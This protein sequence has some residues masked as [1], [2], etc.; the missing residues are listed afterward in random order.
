MNC[1][2]ERTETIDV[3]DSGSSMADE[4]QF[5][6][7]SHREKVVEHVFL[8][9]LLRHLWV[10]RIAG[11]QVLK[12]EVD[13]AGYDLVLAL[14]KVIRHVQLKTSMHD[15]TTRSQPIHAS[16][17][18]VPS[19]CVVWIR[20]NEDLRFNHF[21]W[22]GGEPGQQLPDLT[23][24]KRAKHTRANAQGVKSVRVQTWAVPESKFERVA[25]LEGLVGR[26]FG[27]AAAA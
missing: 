16:L 23:R 21:R 17:G 22:F 19:G 13:A 2:S 25:D 26:L 10:R 3:K 12:P 8:G 6:N 1:L 18:E 5:L 4:R 24:F 9:E 20:L 27:S 15:A 14:G 11:V 7:S